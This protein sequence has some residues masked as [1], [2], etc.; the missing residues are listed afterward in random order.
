MSII[1]FHCLLKHKITFVENVATTEFEKECWKSKYETFASINPLFDNKLG[2]IEKFDFGHVVTEGYFLFK[3][4]AL[5]GLNNRLRIIFN[6]R[7]FEIKRI[8]DVNEQGKIQK[9]IALEL[10]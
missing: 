7:I 8:I 4:R 1:P 3:L 5:N 9:I 2:S 10:V 6:T